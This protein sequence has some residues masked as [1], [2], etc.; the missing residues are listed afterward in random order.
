MEACEIPTEG[1]KNEAFSQHDELP[2]VT[3][4]KISSFKNVDEEAQEFHQ[5]CSDSH[6]TTA[7][8]C[9]LKKPK[10]Q[11]GIKEAVKFCI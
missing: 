11:S 8:S 3:T 5:Q 2:K 10:K 6:T 1:T 7:T 4:S 9:S